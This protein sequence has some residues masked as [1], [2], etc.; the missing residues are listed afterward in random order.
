[1]IFV[2]FDYV[3]KENLLATVA[4]ADT[5]GIGKREIRAVSPSRERKQVG[6]VKLKERL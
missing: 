2:R 6:L 3:S 4:N 5:S 1:M